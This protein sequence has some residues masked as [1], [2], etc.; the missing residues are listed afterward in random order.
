M[1]RI[2]ELRNSHKLTQQELSKIIGIARCSISKIEQGLLDISTDD[3][4]KFAEF[5]EVST[6]YLLGVSD[7][8]NNCNDEY[9]QVIQSA[10]HKKITA[11]KLKKIID[12]LESD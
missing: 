6:D 1:N 5:F 8:K 3:T 7:I 2:K 11:E 4:R 12:I 9:I 10:K